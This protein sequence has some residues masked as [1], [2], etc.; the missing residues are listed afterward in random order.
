MSWISIKKWV[1]FAGLM[2][3]LAVPA[4]AEKLFAAEVVY[5][6]LP[7]DQ[8]LVENSSLPDLI[9]QL[10]NTTGPFSELSTLPVF[11]ASIR[12]FGLPDAFQLGVEKVNGDGNFQVTLTSP[13][14]GLN[15]TFEAVDADAMRKQVVDWLY[16]TGGADA[17]QLLR[18]ITIAAS[19]AV[20]DGGPGTTTARMADTAFQLFGF[21]TGTSESM[22]MRGSESG[23]HVGFS[24]AVS[25]SEVQSPVGPIAGTRTQVAVPL[26]LHFNRRISYVGQV[27]FHHAEIEGTRFY[28][29]GADMGLAYRLIVR[30]GDKRF[31]WQITPYI[32]SHA[33]GSVDGVTAALLYQY[34]LN[35]RLEYRL[36]ERMLLSWVSQ[37]TDFANLT[38]TID[39]IDIN[40]E[41]NQQIFKNG[42][43]FESPLFSLKS[44]YAHGYLTDT[45]FLQEAQFDNYQTIGAGLSYRLTRFSLT[46]NLGFTN[47]DD[48]QSTQVKLACS[49]DL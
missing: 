25:S 7:A 36:G 48:Y 22:D 18:A 38:L 37:Y 10:V 1:I 44:L 13:L 33:I 49:W 2:L 17:K 43:M 12:Y 8:L 20:T 26:W 31:G 14:T 30:E 3:L 32:G 24:V 11:V 45:R 21:Y 9:E 23:A 28:G 35:N 19:A 5:G 6:T 41:V 40:A 47:T 46:G 4:Q 29:I 34:G 39:D 15:K 16:L 27:N 42:V